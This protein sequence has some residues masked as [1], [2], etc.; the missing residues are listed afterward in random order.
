MSVIRGFFQDL[1]NLKPYAI[2]IG[3]GAGYSGYLDYADSLFHH[4][5][6]SGS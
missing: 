4:E 1:A 3:C 6:G 5:N 2:Q